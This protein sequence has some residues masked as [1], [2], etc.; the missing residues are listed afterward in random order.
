MKLARLFSVICLSAVGVHAQCEATPSAALLEVET[1]W[2]R[3]YSVVYGVPL[4]LMVRGFWISSSLRIP[5]S[6]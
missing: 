2:A 3:H 4:E 5:G 1:C 6:M